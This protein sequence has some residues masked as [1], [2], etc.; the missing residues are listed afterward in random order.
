MTL[1][2]NNRNIRRSVRTKFQ[3]YWAGN[4]TC[5]SV[6]LCL[7][8]KINHECISLRH[9]SKT[10]YLLQ[11]GQALICCINESHDATKHF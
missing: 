2:E 11:P 3:P 7:N 5:T 9:L 8:G 10:D 1:K 4:H 6:G